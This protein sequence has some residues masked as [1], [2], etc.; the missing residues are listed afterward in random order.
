MKAPLPSA[1]PGSAAL[2]VAAVCALAT[3]VTTV[4]LWALLLATPRP[5][6]FADEVALHANGAH[7]ARLWVNFAHNLLALVAY[8]GAAALLWRRS[9]GLAAAGLLFFVLWGFV[10]LVG[11]SVNLFAL[12]GTWRAS[13]AAA[14]P[15]VRASLAATMRAWSAVW[16]ALFFV[17]LVAFLLG[18]LCFGLAAA[19][20]RGL[21]RVVGW[22]FLLAV[23]L[24]AAILADGYFGVVT[25][26]A[27]VSWTYPLLQPVSRALLGV[28]MWRSARD[29]LGSPAPA[30]AAPVRT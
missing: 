2:R 11:V 6:S 10:E 14:D 22:L 19:G 4:L 29:A 24:T 28:W 20:G 8:L 9:A 13:Y 27:L 18:T 1:A 3:S 5:G 15:G 17:L 30:G 21:E 12:N 23:P 26:G 25:A 7:L 16:D